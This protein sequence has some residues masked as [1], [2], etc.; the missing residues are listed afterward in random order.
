MKIGVV[1]S[2]LV[3]I[4][5]NWKNGFEN[6][7]F[8]YENGNKKLKKEQKKRHVNKGVFTIGKLF[9]KISRLFERGNF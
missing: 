8:V 9:N 7:L 6:N 2:L 4:N 3:S 1:N 5:R